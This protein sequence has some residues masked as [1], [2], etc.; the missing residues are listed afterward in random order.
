MIYS[1][2]IEIKSLRFVVLFSFLVVLWEFYLNFDLFYRAS[3][4]QGLS[5]TVRFLRCLRGRKRQLL[6]YPYWCGILLWFFL[7]ISSYFWYS[8]FF[9]GCSDNFYFLIVLLYFILFCC[10]LF[11]KLCIWFKICDFLLFGITNNTKNLS[12]WVR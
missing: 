3:V 6:L 2:I 11:N 4:I 7:I 8:C 10:L 1:S 12:F 9:L 5:V